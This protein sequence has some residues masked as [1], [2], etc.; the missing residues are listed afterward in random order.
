MDSGSDW[1]RNPD[2]T[3]NAG[4]PRVIAVF[5][6]YTEA[7]GSPAIDH[8]VIEAK[9]KSQLAS[10]FIDAAVSSVDPVAVGAKGFVSIATVDID[11]VVTLRN[12]L[13]REGM[14]DPFRRCAILP[15]GKRTVQVLAVDWTVVNSSF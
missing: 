8:N 10:R 4:L 3:V 13:R 5:D 15:A 14:R 11:H 9:R 12:D 7:G 2:S 6:R 1:P